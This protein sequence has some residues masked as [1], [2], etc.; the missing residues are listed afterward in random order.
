VDVTTKMMTTNVCVLFFGLM[1]A[2]KTFTH[3]VV[4]SI[5]YFPFPCYALSLVERTIKFVKSVK[6]LI[7]IYRGISG[8]FK[9]GVFEFIRPIFLRICAVSVNP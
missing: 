4:H 5:F 2:T 9:H 1:L 6:A 3:C 8:R 7:S